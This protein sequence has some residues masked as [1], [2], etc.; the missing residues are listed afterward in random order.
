MS[1]FS[2]VTI[3]IDPDIQEAVINDLKTAPRKFRRL[4]RARIVAIQD[5][6]L[7]RLQTPAPPVKYPIQWKT[8]KQR[9][10]YF[11][12]NGFGKGIPTRR[13]GALQK[14]WKGIIEG[15]IREGLFTLYNDATTRDYFTGAIVYYEQFVTGTSQQPFHRNTGWVRSQD[16]L[17][18]AMVE[19]EDAMIQT[20][21]EVNG[22]K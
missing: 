12:T 8:Q 18:D 15:D 14:G 5:R 16:V 20:W 11:A 7:R 13:T 2:A 9:R 22:A 21:W 10:A 17:A 3:T 1:S 4:Y 19:A 6:T